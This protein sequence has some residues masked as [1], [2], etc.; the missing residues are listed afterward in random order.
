VHNNVLRVLE[1][2]GFFLIFAHVVGSVWWSIGVAHFNRNDEDEVFGRPRG[3]SWVIR[4][5]VCYPEDAYPARNGSDIDMYC[6]TEAISQRLMSATY[7]SLTALI[8]TPWVHPDTV[9]EKAYATVMVVVGA[10][11][12]AAI[13]GNIT[14]MI[15]SFDKS[16]AQ[17]REVM[18]TLN[19]LIGKYDV[20]SKL[21]KRVF[22]YVQTQ[23]A[24][25]K[26]LD[27]KK[28]LA[29]MPPAL[30]GDILEAI[31]A[32]VVQNSA[33]FSRVSQEC[34]RVMLSKLRGEMCLPKETLLNSGQICN[35]VFVLQ[36]GVLQV[37]PGES[38][39]GGK[40]GAKGKML[41][42]AIEKTG[43]LVGMRDPF[44]KDYRYPFNVVAIK[45]AHLV[46]LTGKDLLEV[47]A[48]DNRADIEAICEVLDKEYSDIEAALLKGQE[49]LAARR[50]SRTS[51]RRSSQGNVETSSLATASATLTNPMTDPD[52][53]H[54][55]L[56]AIEDS[57]RAATGEIASIKTHLA[58]LPQLCDIL[59]IPY[60]TVNGLAVP[61]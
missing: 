13:L 37:Q 27:T 6:S 49:G 57:V 23:W 19:R 43:A 2:L 60:K 11:V 34:V 56:S 14:A 45:Q 12:F 33:M 51:R 29:K 25:T 55:R 42:R 5:H 17:L 35:E 46:A 4:S 20:P 39:G 15:N 18:A 38:G 47:F 7:W 31:Y 59:D 41:F 28:I 44:E 8:K 40:K 10:V 30:R 32:D 16:N 48:M 26:G 53:V 1:M 22:M 9:I 24:T 58:N 50:T 61:V 3:S 54:L 36:R 52:E 21:Q